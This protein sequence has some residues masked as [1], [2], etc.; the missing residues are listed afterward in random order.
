VTLS[1]AKPI[2]VADHVTRGGRRR[3]ACCG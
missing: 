3:P 1:L 2:S